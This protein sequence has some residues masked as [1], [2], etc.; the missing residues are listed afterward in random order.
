MERRRHYFNRTQTRLSS[1]TVFFLSALYFLFLRSS[2]LIACFLLSSFLSFALLLHVFPQQSVLPVSIFETT[3]F[4]NAP[5]VLALFL[6]PC[7][8]LL[9]QGGS[10]MTGT[11]CV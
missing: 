11:I 6:S 3:P 8:F 2:F 4:Q 7:L 9:L 5:N 1:N 10:N